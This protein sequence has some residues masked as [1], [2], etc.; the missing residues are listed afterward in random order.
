MIASARVLNNVNIDCHGAQRVGFLSD[1]GAFV[2]SMGYNT[3]VKIRV[4]FRY[5]HLRFSY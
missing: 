1:S 2:S 5:R 3:P 4:W